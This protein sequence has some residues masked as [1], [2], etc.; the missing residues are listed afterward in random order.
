[1]VKN[2]DFSHKTNYIA[3]FSE[4]LKQK[5]CIGS[6]ITAILRNGWI[7]LLVELQWE[8]SAPAACAAGLFY[9]IY[10]IIFSSATLS[11]KYQ[12]SMRCSTEK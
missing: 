8:Q 5:C 4:I 9:N 7:C 6:K 11:L 2:G 1:M 12:C 10:S 3:F